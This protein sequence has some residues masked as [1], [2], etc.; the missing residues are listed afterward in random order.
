MWLSARDK[1]MFQKLLSFFQQ[2]EPDGSLSI[3]T[4]DSD[5]GET[6]NHFYGESA[7]MHLLL[8]AACFSANLLAL[9]AQASH[10]I[11][12][13]T[14]TNCC[15]TM[16]SAVKALETKLENLIALVKKTSTSTPQPTPP[17]KLD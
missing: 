16:I 1:I 14:P 17:G 15:N 7:R 12:N 4:Q 13:H 3:Q 2:K 10:M 11:P 9:T 6:R 5:S 8:F